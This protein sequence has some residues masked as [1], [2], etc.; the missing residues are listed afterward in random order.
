MSFTLFP[1]LCFLIKFVI[2]PVDKCFKKHHLNTLNGPEISN[3]HIMT[4]LYRR[5]WEML[6]SILMM[7]GDVMWREVRN[8]T[9]RVFFFFFFFFFFLANV[10]LLLINIEQ[11]KIYKVSKLLLLLLKETN[12][13]K[14]IFYSWLIDVDC[15]VDEL[16]KELK[17]QQIFLKYKDL[18]QKQLDQWY[19]A[20]C[21]H[22][23]SLRTQIVV[24][25]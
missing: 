6:F 18:S 23:R 9:G 17:F 24:H 3:I 7:N 22:L 14:F 1:L 11:E 10:H 16:T 12:G 20:F 2:L 13:V 5:A 19:L 15:I 25:F 4:C 21:T 8:P